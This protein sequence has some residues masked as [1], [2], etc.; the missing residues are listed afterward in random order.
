MW[1]TASTTKRELPPFSTL[2]ENYKFNALFSEIKQPI[3]FMLVKRNFFFPGE[4]L[5]NHDESKQAINVRNVH[6]RA[7]N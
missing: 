5:A 2:P 1:Q 4:E 6:E 3:S 7:Q